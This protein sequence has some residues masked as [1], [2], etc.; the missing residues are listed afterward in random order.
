MYPSLPHHWRTGILQSPDNNSEQLAPVL[1]ASGETPIRLQIHPLNIPM[2]RLCRCLTLVDGLGHGLGAKHIVSAG[3]HPWNCCLQG[4][5]IDLIG[6]PAGKLEIGALICGV[7]YLLAD[8][9][10]KRVSLDEKLAPLLGNR[11][12]PSRVVWLSPGP[13]GYSGTPVSLPFSASNPL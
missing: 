13:C 7:V 11:P 8:G 2:D 12:P 6:A 5:R 4:D 10:D 3:K 9:R 1:H